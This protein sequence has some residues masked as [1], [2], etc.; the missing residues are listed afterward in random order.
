MYYDEYGKS[1]NHTIVF[2][3]GA[4]ATD[5]FCNQYCFQD[6]YHLVVPHL[7][8]CGK[9]VQEI[10]EPEKTIKALAELIKGLGKDKV[11]LIGHSLGGELA[12]AMVSQYE[13][14][15]DKAVFLSAWVCATQKS[16]DK[17]VK[18]A[19][20]SSFALKFGW[21]IRFQAKYWHYTKQQADFMVEYSRKITPEQYTAWFKKRILLDECINYSKINIPMLAVCG[22][23][24]V[25]EIIRSVEELGRRNSKCKT[26]FLDNVNH[27]FP[28]RQADILNPI[29]IDFI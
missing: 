12:V 15:F 22:K 6:K 8:G 20:Y 25:K 9:E 19:R 5:T 7:Y 1:E 24:E 26:I 11:T 13:F 18:I 23:K 29:L 4:A 21:L 10:Y 27:D 17:Y 16:I 3:H 14:L 2:L 28:L